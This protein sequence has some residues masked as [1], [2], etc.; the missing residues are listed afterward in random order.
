MARDAEQTKRRLLEAATAEFAA[1]GI[2]GARVDR[3][4]AAAGCNK[5]MIY[6]Y[7]DSKDGLFDAVF[8][9]QTNAFFEAVPFDASDL[10]GYLGRAFDYFEEHPENLRLSTWH[11]LERSGSEHLAAIT[12]VND[13]RLREIGRAQRAGEISG[14]FSPVQLLVLVQAL[15]A[16]WHS[17]NPELGP[18][19]PAARAARRRTLV[20]AVQGLLALK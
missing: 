6:S 19:V 9:E 13:V 8:D 17:T 11:R 2:A 15:S 10:A 14:H 16:A 12:E 18:H 3:I 1:Y 4:A 7:F 5:A 20:D